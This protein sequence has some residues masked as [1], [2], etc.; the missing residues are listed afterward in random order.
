MTEAVARVWRGCGAGVA[1][2][3]R[4]CSIPLFDANQQYN[5]SDVHQMKDH[6]RI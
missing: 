6:H 2:V 3:W 5:V 4:G 1:R